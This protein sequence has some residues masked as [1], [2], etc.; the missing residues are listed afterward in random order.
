MADT[1]GVIASNRMAETDYGWMYYIKSQPWIP[2]Y[3]NED[4]YV[5]PT[6]IEKTEREL[7]SVGA[8]KKRTLLWPRKWQQDIIKARNGKI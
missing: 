7:L 1:S 4:V 5:A 2:H 3:V 8:M 6:G